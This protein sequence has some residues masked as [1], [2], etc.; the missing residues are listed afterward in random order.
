MLYFGIL[1]VL[2]CSCVL[3]ISE[4][5]FGYGVIA[6]LAKRIAT[7][8][9][10]YREDRSYEKATLLICLYGIGRAGRCEPAAGRF[11]GR[12]KPLVQS[13]EPYHYVLHIT[14]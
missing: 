8:Y 11:Q 3:R 9:A 12:N 14:L 13:D 6:T 2:P 7:E 10:P 5:L 4:S 1:L